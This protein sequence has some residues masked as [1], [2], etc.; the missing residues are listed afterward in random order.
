MKTLVASSCLI[1]AAMA[2]APAENPPR[3]P[4]PTP[5]A[6]SEHW[7]FR[8]PSR[9]ELPAVKNSAWV[10]NPID[11]FIAAEHER[12]GLA[13]NPPAD[14]A[15]LLRRVTID[16]IGLPPTRE[17]LQSF[18]ADSSPDAYEKVVDRLLQSQQY[19]ERWARH[20]MD[21]WRYS[22]WYGRRQVPDV[23][24]S[25]PQV[26]RWRDWI[27]RS[28]NNDKGYDRMVMEMVAADEIAPKDD[29]NAVATGYL[30]RNWYALNPNQWMRENVEHTGKAFLGLTIQCAHC[31]D[32]KYDPI[33]QEEYFRFRAF[34]EPIELRQDR[35]PGEA[36]PGPF[37]KYEY[38][39]LRKIQKLGSVRIFDDRLDA[40]TIMYRGGDERSI[41]EGKPPVEPGVPSFLGGDKLKIEPVELPPAA[42]YPGLKEFIRQDETA[43]REAGLTSAQTGL[44]TA[45]KALASSTDAANRPGLESAVRVSEVQLANAHAQ[46][47]SIQT[48]IAADNARYLGSNG[49][50]Q[51]LTELASHAER[52]ANFLQARE[53]LAI[54]EQA[55]AVANQKTASDPNAKDV[56][57]KLEQQIQQTKSAM[58]MAWEATFAPATTYTPLSPIYPAKSTGRRRALAQWL[59]SRD[60]PLTA[61]VA[62]NHI[63]MRHFGRPL[64]ETVFDFGR[65]G[66]HPSHPEL[67]DWLA[68]EFMESGW[69]MKKL[70]RLIVTSNTYKQDSKIADRGLLIAEQKNNNQQSATSNP[71]FPQSPLTT[72]HSPSSIDTDNRFLWRMNPRRMEAEVVHDSILFAAGQLDLTI[73]GIPLE[74]DQ[75]NASRRRGL[76]FSVYPEDGG[77]MK[78][79][80]TF[81]APDAC[82]CYRRTESMVPQQALALTNS[83]TALNQGRL[84]ARKLWFDLLAREPIEEIRQLAF[85][86]AAFE[87]IVSRRPTAAEQA[88][89]LEFLRKQTDLFR[90]ADPEQLTAAPVDGL[91]AASS[92]PALRA[93]E[94][95]V[96]SLFSHNDFVTVR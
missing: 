30:V 78:F 34:F 65:N 42:F 67:F 26:W 90:S 73:G 85:I 12:R 22:D 19:G 15:T 64:V 45:Q 94:S 47:K 27:V 9:P 51:R 63:W 72:H 70:H 95:L 23:W 10:K 49:D 20:W 31:H 66:K 53:N 80:E 77:H 4:Q 54:A 57:K 21:V 25:A 71:Q 75:E 36:D 5:V 59:A 18:L 61:R 50:T 84:L 28:L 55:L 6:A 14:K 93:C 83:R 44:A 89:C 88:V 16:L 40:K 46:L 1:L 86:T 39:V 2:A 41:M 56:A 35:V 3:T 74:N 17:E 96:Q 79:L 13:P 87:Q 58:E 7:A 68:V 38:S 52:K 11:A 81:D 29:E 32:H 43:R 91:I 33:S 24:N 82:D 60:N 92:D 62:V 37:Q 8:V 48:R 76:Y 69:S